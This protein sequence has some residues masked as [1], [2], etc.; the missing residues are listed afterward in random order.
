M[1]KQLKWGIVLQYLQMGL[2][3]IINLIYTPIMLRILGQSEYG[4]YNLASSIIGYLSLLS[5]GFG[6]SYIRFYSRYKAEN[7]EDKIKKLNGLYMLVFSIIG[8]ISLIAGLVL[9][10]NVKIFFNSSYTTEEMKIA[11]VLMLFLTANLAL[12]FP[13]S[14]FTSYITSQEKFIFQKLINIISTVLSPCLTIASLFLGYGSIGMVFITTVISLIVY[15]INIF[16]CLKKLKMRFSFGKLEKGIFK[17]I[18]VFSIFIAINEVINQINW[19]TDKIILG[20][21]IN[22]SAVAI[23]AVGSTINSMYI[24]FSTAISNVFVPQIHRIVNEN[25]EDSDKKLTEIFVKVGRIQF[26]V[27]MLVLTGFIFFGQK[28]IGFWAGKG[29]EQSYYVAL[30]LICPVTIPLMQN[31]GIEIQRAKNK[32]QFRSIAYL[33]M[34]IINVGISILLC[35]AYGVIGVAMGT[36]ISLLVAN[37]LVMNVYYHKALKINIIKF[38]LTILKSAL[39]IIIPVAFGVVVM[40][41]IDYTSFIAMVGLIVA[42]T[43]IYLVSVL[44]LGLNKQEK[45]ALKNKLMRKKLKLNAETE[46]NKIISETLPSD[47]TLDI[48]EAIINEP[49][50][51]Q[52]EDIFEA[53]SETTSYTEKKIYDKS[54]LKKHNKKDA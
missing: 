23:Y 30:L 48:S 4:L 13:M 34:A 31:I 3:V 21:V 40:L 24:N 14:V 52:T 32:H 29:Y 51:T 37:G 25:S 50:N 16:Y 10:F 5:L 36:T 17:E 22:G 54:K 42:Y 8:A 9:S 33:I 12:S 47:K 44:F 46:S 19:Q 26:F 18:L 49:E 20:K 38:W 39:G 6:A 53:D 27:I 28:F 35:K 41:F 15:A 7:A 11:K 1:N 45:L 43:A 2:S